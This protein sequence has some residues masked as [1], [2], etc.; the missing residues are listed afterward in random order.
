[1][2]LAQHDLLDSLD[3][4]LSAA[5]AAVA[6]SV[7]QLDRGHGG[8]T[9]LA[10][11]DDLAVT[12]SFHCPDETEVLV[13]NPEG[14]VEPR[15]ATVI[16]RD[17]GLDLAL[18]RVAGGGLI[19][20]VHRDPSS[21]AVGNLAIAVGRPG[22]SARASMRM[23]SV[24]GADV[25]TPAGGVLDVYLET[26]RLLPRGFAGGPLVDAQGRVIGMS[27]RTLVRGHDLAVPVSAIAR[28]VAQLLQH[29]AIPRGYLGVGVTA[30]ALSRQLADATGKRHGALVSALDDGGPAERAGLRQGDIILSLAGAAITG[31][32]ELRQVVS[33]HPGDEV[34]VE[35]LRG[36]ALTSFAV[37]LGNRS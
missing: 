13:S 34:T 5:V 19:V 25:R 6:S 8:G 11:S 35:A 18:L 31:P 22:R 15:K 16:G 33:E 29:G 14:G 4:A 21:L 27:T 17:P 20:P 2:A 12:S 36:G 28:S 32:T 9:A 37:T 10:W 24:R 26:D 1:M 30:V 23:I 3:Q 7:L